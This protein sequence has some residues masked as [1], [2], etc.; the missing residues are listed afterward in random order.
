MQKTT[1]TATTTTYKLEALAEQLSKLRSECCQS[2]RSG[3][4]DEIRVAALR[5][6]EFMKEQVNS[7]IQS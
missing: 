3:R 1:T 5:L 6:E 4:V 2:N 7:Y